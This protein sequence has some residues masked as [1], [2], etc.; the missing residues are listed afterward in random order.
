MLEIMSCFWRKVPGFRNESMSAF[1]ELPRRTQR[2]PFS[3]ERDPD[4]TVLHRRSPWS[5]LPSCQTSAPQLSGAPQPLCAPSAPPPQPQF[6]PAPLQC[7]RGSSACQAANQ[8][9]GQLERF[10]TCGCLA[11]PV[12]VSQH[13]LILHYHIPF[14]WHISPCSFSTV[15][16][17]ELQSSHSDLL[18]AFYSGGLFLSFL[19]GSFLGSPLF[20][21]IF[22]PL[23]LVQQLST[24]CHCYFLASCVNTVKNSVNKR[25]KDKFRFLGKGLKSMLVGMILSSFGANHVKRGGLHG[26]PPST[27]EE[28]E[29]SAPYHL[30]PLEY[31][32]YFPQPLC[33]G[34]G[35]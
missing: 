3:R 20:W 4:N 23:C 24:S 31:F 21:P 13:V 30:P 2:A 11:V 12:P 10:F 19:F 8:Y 22:T 18:T 35:E 6:F 16:G 5:L 1:A 27:I 34:W 7:Q 33:W 14:S 26:S 29:L 9:S 15:L 25:G 32:N 28:G 17:P